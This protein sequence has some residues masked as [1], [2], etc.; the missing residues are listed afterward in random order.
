MN[1]MMGWLPAKDAASRSLVMHLPTSAFSRLRDYTAESYYDGPAEDELTVSEEVKQ[2]LSI[3]FEQVGEGITQAESEIISSS[4]A[5]D[6]EATV[7]NGLDYLKG[8]KSGTEDFKNLIA[9]MTIKFFS[10][11]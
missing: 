3:F 2:Y 11:P 1:I 6:E 7:S 8:N 10:P 5:W 9:G 4:R